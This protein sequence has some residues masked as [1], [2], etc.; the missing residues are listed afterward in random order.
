VLDARVQSLPGS[1]VLVDSV[2][3]GAPPIRGVRLG[4]EETLLEVRK[5]GERSGP[6]LRLRYRED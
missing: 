5:P 3:R 4:A 6:Q 1:I 2:S